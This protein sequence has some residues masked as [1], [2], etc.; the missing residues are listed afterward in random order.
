ME[1][2]FHC[3]NGS[4]RSISH[5]YPVLYCYQTIV[6][7]KACSRN[8]MGSTNLAY[9]EKVNL[10]VSVE[11]SFQGLPSFLGKEKLAKW[12]YFATRHFVH[13]SLIFATQSLV[14]SLQHIKLCI[15]LFSQS[16]S[17]L[18]ITYCHERSSIN[19]ESYFAELVSKNLNSLQSRY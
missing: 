6:I 15:S 3:K 10:Q 8:I 9:S 13:P 4:L 2:F 16:V 7:V 18:V 19:S 11:L 14:I 5:L 1:W 17:T 12:T